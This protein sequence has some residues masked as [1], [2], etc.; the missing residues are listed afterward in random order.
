MGAEVGA[1]RTRARA[2]LVQFQRAQLTVAHPTLHSRAGAVARRFTS[3]LAGF[4]TTLTKVA[5]N[6][7]LEKTEEFY[8][9]YHDFFLETAINDDSNYC[10]IF[11]G[12]Q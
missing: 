9:V 1:A 6:R 12:S 8:T 2:E 7:S 3:P 4:L 11:G 5:N 10:L